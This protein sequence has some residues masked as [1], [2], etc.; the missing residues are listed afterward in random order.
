[1]DTAPIAPPPGFQLDPP[2]GG[3][4]VPQP[5]AGFQVDATAPV[6]PQM[7]QRNPTLMDRVRDI[8]DDIRTSRPVE[9]LL[10]RTAQEIAAEPAAEGAPTTHDAGVMGLFSNKTPIVPDYEDPKTALDGLHNW[11]AG[12][13]NSVASPGGLATAPLTGPAKIMGPIVQKALLLV[14]GA[15]GGKLSYDAAKD[16]V[17]KHYVPPPPAGF[18]PDPAATR[19]GAQTVMDVGNILAGGVMLLGG[20]EG[21]KRGQTETATT[22]PPPHDDWLPAAPPETV[23]PPPPPGFVTDPAQPGPAAVQTPGASSGAATPPSEPAVT[24]ASEIPNSPPAAATAPAGP[25][26][27]AGGPTVATTGEP[28]RIVLNALDELTSTR[29]PVP[30]SLLADSGVAPT[31]L[32]TGYQL[33]PAG[34]H[35]E[36][37]APPPTVTPE[38]QMARDAV[39]AMAELRQVKPAELNNEGAKPPSSEPATPS[40]D[41]ARLQLL[42]VDVTPADIK[43]ASAQVERT[44]DVLDYVQENF[45]TGVKF[46]RADF[47]E[48]VK[49]S[50]GAAAELMSHTRGEPADQVLKALHED[51]Q[52][53]RLQTPDDLANAMK[54]AGDRRINERDGGSAALELARQQKRTE[55]FQAAGKPRP[56]QTEPTEASQL[57]PGDT[58]KLKGQPVKV[59][60]K[61][62][63]A[64][65]G[66]PSHLRV[67][68]AYGDQTIPADGVVHL[69]KGSLKMT[70]PAGAS[71]NYPELHDDALQPFEKGPGY[72]LKEEPGH[73]ETWHIPDDELERESDAL[74]RQ[75]HRTPQEEARLQALNAEWETRNAPLK[76]VAL[77][78]P[79]PKE[80]VPYRESQSAAAQAPRDLPDKTAKGA[81]A[82]RRQPTRRAGAPPTDLARAL[83][84]DADSTKGDLAL[85]EKQR[86]HTGE[87]DTKQGTFEINGRLAYLDQYRQTL[88][89][90]AKAAQGKDPVAK[91]QALVDKHNRDQD[92]YDQQHP[93]TKNKLQD[94]VQFGW[95]RRLQGSADAI[96]QIQER[97][98]TKSLTQSILFHLDNL[99]LDT[100][101][102]LHAFGLAPEVWNTLIDGIKLAVRGGAALA[103]AITTGIARLKASGADLKDFNEAAAVVHLNENFGVR[104]FGQQLQDA[105]DITSALKGDV[106]NTIYQ[107]RPQEDDA[108]YAGRILA[109]V[110]SADKAIQVF[111]DEHR[112]PQPVRM[113]LGMQIVKSLDAAGRYQDAAQF[114]DNHLAP[115][116][117][118]VAQG[119]A[120]LNAWRSMSKD[121]KLV[122]AQRKLAAARADAI[123]PVRPDIEAARTELEKQNA[124]GIE[125]T[126]ADA[127]VQREAKQAIT[128]AVANSPETHAGVV[129]ELAPV[130][131]Q[132]KYILDTAR[133]KVAAKA[134]ELLTKQPRPIGFTTAQHLRSIMDDL[135]KRAAEIAAGHYQGAEPGV[136]LRDK[137]VQRLGISKDAATSLAAA[138]DKEFARQVNAA[139]D[140][141]PRRIAAQ[142]ERTRQGLPNGEESAVDKS[143]RQQLAQGKVKLGTL[144]REH[145]TKVDATG[146]DLKDKL[147]KQ[148]GLTGDAAQRLADLIAKRFEALTANAKKAAL[149]RILKPVQ[150]I[151]RPQLVDRLIKLSNVGAFD[152][153]K[154]WNAIRA[155]LDLPEW[156]QTLRDRLAGIADRI[157]KIPGDR[158]ED[159]QRA[160]TEFL[161]EVEKA[162]GISNT[163]LGLAFYMQNILSGVTTH[164]RVAIHTSAQ[165]MGAVTA[166]MEQALVQGRLHD[167]PLIFEALARGA[168]KAFTQQKD[169]MRTGMVVGSKLQSVV[170]LSVLEQI[171]FGQKG[172]ATAK[173][174]RMATALIESKAATLLNAWKYNGRLITAQHMLYFKPA[175]EMKIALLAARQA[176]TEG[177]TGRAAVDRARQ[178]AGYGAAQVRAAEAQA[179]REG[180]TGT[181]AKMRTSEILNAGISP[182]IKVNARDYA[183]RQTFLNEPYGFVGGIAK[184]VQNAKSSEHPAVALGARLIVPFTRIAANLFNEGLNYTPIGAARARFAQTELAGNKFADITPEVRDDLRKEL[185]A[186]AALGTMLTTAIAFKAA[187]GLSQANPDF[188]VYGSGPANPQDKNAWR[189]AGGI[190]Y[191]VKIGGRYVSY[192]NT[193]ANVMLA[194]LGNY[195]DASRD[196][197]LYKRPGALRLA[198]DLPLRTAAALVGMGKVIME[199]P[200][201]QS[202]LDVANLSAQQNPELSAK[203]TIKT[204]ARTASSLVIPNIFRQ[205]DKFEDPTAY[206]TKTLGGILTSQ[207]P[208]V[209]QTGR[210]LLNALGQPIQSPVF[211]QL[212]GPANADTLVQMLTQHNFWPSTPDRNQTTVRGVPLN[213]DEFYLYLKTRGEA[214]AKLLASPTVAPLLDRLAETKDNLTTRAATAVNPITKAILAK[215]AAGLQNEVLGK[216]EAAANKLAEAAVIRVRGY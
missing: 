34:T 46:D 70:E 89:T 96:A 179:S 28:S 164:V 102:Q 203:Q 80:E 4:T 191:S 51:G 176:R 36:F 53:L 214:L 122:W 139:K 150:R 161:N 15:Q 32:A 135:A 146:A 54:G 74:A 98:A 86:L 77:D 125:R 33:N 50:R 145:W 13:V 60:E 136:I 215:K 49:T 57:F 182:A 35:Y 19:T 155:G 209:R 14:F 206:D 58:F 147:V 159:T 39:Q 72:G 100:R 175:E 204:V 24:A 38:Q 94:P 45:P 153:D 190:P 201:L 160:Q 64:E 81:G 131:A 192:A 174:G 138:L 130:W 11:A 162:K 92:R 118:D 18:V 10:G 27:S 68:G 17:Q 21:L 44:P 7:S 205:L 103:D 75:L 172:G 123:A 134:N 152:T 5:P 101:G 26:A 37:T 120:M 166:E 87:M 140:A 124:A 47:G 66:K 108:S 200:Y 99:K 56:G 84:A 69:D 114:F 129:M 196:A 3:A 177:L 121:G 12:V 30:A 109:D 142:I 213:D 163:E 78:K 76:P 106:T 107:R 126:T 170:P 29:Q 25:A 117:T 208:F 188:A 88:L 167:V 16:L 132:S 154:Y 112:L 110:G 6:I 20:K 141:L 23:V 55:Q 197:M 157:A 173:Q 143:I 116:T 41:V 184:V 128:E 212:T 63:D 178:I 195:L 207:M 90:A 181:P 1:M 183:L 8:G 149:Q 71:A 151:A 199:Q 194:A 91:L 73:P 137:L 48:L 95:E 31:S 165:M 82:G 59:E 9:T 156:S 40:E 216:Y 169:I 104:Q 193:P 65:T 2:T 187:Q 144:V 52:F 97:L 119:L 202:L 180:L 61:V 186:K 105:S 158:L 171:H 93:L 148:T 211:G 198:G 111:A 168:G 127:A 115:A 210:P 133:A 22:P 185:Y 43:R 83:L 79:Q 189:A 85:L 62:V 67:S 113:A 42:P